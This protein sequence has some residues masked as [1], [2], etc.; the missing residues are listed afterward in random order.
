MND[1]SSHVCWHV[2]GLLQ[3]ADHKYDEAIKCYRNALK[4]D[5]VSM[6]CYFWCLVLF[7]WDEMST[8]VLRFSICVSVSLFF[9][10]ILIYSIWNFGKSQRM[11]KSFK[12]W[13]PYICS[14]C[15]LEIPCYDCFT[16]FVKW[17]SANEHRSIRKE[18]NNK[19][20][21]FGYVNNSGRVTSSSSWIKGNN[22]LKDLIVPTKSTTTSKW[23]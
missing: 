18:V 1:L 23:G 12:V 9:L 4:W 20:I 17:A 21:I 15:Y 13:N 22:S 3:R 14:G 11:R 19:C 2:F 6:K 8:F 5:K 7:F 16:E 10:F